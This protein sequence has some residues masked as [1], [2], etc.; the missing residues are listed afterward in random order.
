M[1]TFIYYVLQT[2]F[3]AT[4][5]RLPLILNF[6]KAK[7]SKGDYGHLFA[8]VVLFSPPPQH[9]IEEKKITY[10]TCTGFFYFEMA[11]AEQ[12][13]TFFSQKSQQE[14]NYRSYSGYQG[15]PGMG[16]KNVSGRKISPSPITTP[17]DYPSH[18]HPSHDHPPWPF[19]MIIPMT[20]AH[21]HSPWPPLL[22]PLFL[23]PAPMTTSHDHCLWPSPR[24]LPNPHF[25]FSH[26]FLDWRCRPLPP[27]SLICLKLKF[28]RLWF[29]AYSILFYS[30]HEIGL[31]ICDLQFQK[32]KKSLESTKAHHAKKD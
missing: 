32:T 14:L 20:T 21:D 25:H 6:A 27:R 18:D 2:S 15:L 3:P 17:Q 4:Y 9:F 1:L 8:C 28:F 31:V 22:W 23:W 30:I 24:P 10:H 26:Y 16:R 29:E 7:Q 12:M 11:T 5:L 13:G 19:P